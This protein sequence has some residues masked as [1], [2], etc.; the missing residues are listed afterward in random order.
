MLILG[1]ET[2]GKMAS[3]ALMRD[4]L[5]L[6]QKSVYTSRTHS[7]IIMPM[8]TE[9]LEASCLSL[10]DVELLAVSCGPGSYTGLRIGIAAVKALSF[11]KGIPCVGISTLEGMATQLAAF[12]GIVAPVMTARAEFL[13][14]ALFRADGEKLTRLCDDRIIAADLLVSELDALEEPIL[15]TGDIA[16]DLCASHG[17]LLAPPTLRLQSAAGICLAAAD[18]TAVTPDELEAFYMQI[19]KAEKDLQDKRN[20]S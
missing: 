20:E 10:D 15:L 6:A 8:C 4:S 2:S 17:Y 19:T 13:Y 18:K 16:S 11:S 9:L 5:L 1:I 3:V 14:S 7:Q 12:K